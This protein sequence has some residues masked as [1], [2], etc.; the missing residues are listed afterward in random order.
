MLFFQLDYERVQD[1]QCF[2]RTQMKV[3]TQQWQRDLEELQARALVALEEAKHAHQEELELRKD[4][5]HQ[6]D[7]CSHLRQKVCAL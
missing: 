6:Q 2:T 4:R 5:Q 3:V 7:I 1:K